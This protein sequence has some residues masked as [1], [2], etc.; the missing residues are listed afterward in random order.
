L[1][2]H[3]GLVLL[4]D[5]GGDHY[6]F[7][8]YIKMMKFDIDDKKQYQLDLTN[9][10]EELKKRGGRKVRRRVGIGIIEYGQWFMNHQQVVDFISELL[11]NAA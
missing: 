10:Q 8:V 3:I 1:I 2:L 6:Y 7:N 11:K 4:L 5:S 9:W